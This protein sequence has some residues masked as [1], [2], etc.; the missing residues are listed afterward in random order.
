M[1]VIAQL[2]SIGLG[3]VWGWLMG[4]WNA[5]GQRRRPWL[6]ALLSA[7][8]TLLFI[9]PG[10]YYAGPGSAAYLLIPAAISFFIHLV[11][12]SQLRSWAMT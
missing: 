8:A 4:F 7:L 12:L 2:G 10:S 9:L 5:R 1:T 3:L 11:W 6:N